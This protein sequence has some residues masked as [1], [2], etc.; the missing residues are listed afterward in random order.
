ML[1]YVL[2][3]KGL[4]FAKFYNL[5]HTHNIAIH[6]IVSIDYNTF[7]FTI[8]PK[9]YNSLLSLDSF[10]YYDITVIKRG[11]ISY[12]MDKLYEKL[13]VIIGIIISII[14]MIYVSTLTLSISINNA[15][16]SSEAIYNALEQYGIS[17]FKVNTIDEV[18]LEQYLL[19]TVD[20]ISLVDVVCYGTGI[21]INVQEKSVQKEEFLPIIATYDMYITSIEVYSGTAAVAKDSIVRKGDILVNPYIFNENGD[22]QHVVPKVRLQADVWFSDY[23]IYETKTY[24]YVKT[25]NAKLTEYSIIFNG[26]I[27]YTYKN[28]HI[29][30][31]FEVETNT[32]PLFF[33]GCPIV[34]SKTYAYET[35]LITREHNFDI[36]KEEVIENITSKVE[37]IVPKEYD[38]KDKQIE[39]SV[40]SDKYYIVVYLKCSIIEIY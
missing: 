12:I 20:S 21:I 14:S 30:E 25:G 29:F 16:V 22:I 39:I 23:A 37:A 9:H 18:A 36:D 19:D 1:D 33:N 17:L 26:N 27:I 10:K 8:L 2:Q 32:Y 3:Y 15:T 7:N 11:G 13:G 4:N 6:N 24:D 28:N 38:I 40:N 34:I 35:E 5:L 31:H